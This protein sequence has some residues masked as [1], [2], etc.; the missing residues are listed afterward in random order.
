MKARHTYLFSFIS[1]LPVLSVVGPM[2]EAGK[3]MTSEEEKKL[4][5]KVLEEIA[6]NSEFVRDLVPSSGPLTERWDRKAFP[7]FLLADTLS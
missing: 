5:K 3:A 2:V 1:V 6:K 7:I 4:G